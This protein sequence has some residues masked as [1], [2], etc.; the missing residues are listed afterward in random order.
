MSATHSTHDTSQT[1][2]RNAAPLPADAASHDLNDGYVRTHE[3]L[4]RIQQELATS[5]R[6]L[7]AL[8]DE[9]TGLE[10]QLHLKFDELE[11]NSSDLSSLLASMHIAVVFLDPRFCLRRFTPAVADLFDLTATDAGRPL[12]E[13]SRKFNDPALDGD[14]ARVLAQL[15]PLAAEITSDSGRT[16]VRQALPYRT[17]ANRVEGVV[18]TFVDITER[19]RIEQ[20]FAVAERRQRIVLDA[21][22][23]YAIF[24]LDINGRVETWS[25]AAE[26]LLGYE[27]A[28]IVGST[29]DIV[30]TPGDREAELPKRLLAKAA[31]K[32]SVVADHFYMRRDGVRFWGSGMLYAVRDPAGAAVGFVKILRDNSQQRQLE[33]AANEA[34]RLAE[35]ANESKDHFLS[36]V[37]HEL[38]T[39]LSAMM[40]WSH[41]LLNQKDP[42]A[43]QLRE[44]LQAIRACAEEQRALIEDLVDTS[45]IAAGKLRLDR[46]PTDLVATMRS[47]VDAMRP[48]AAERGLSLVETHDPAIG[49][50]FADAHRVHQ[51]VSNLLANAV[52]FTP[53]GGHVS[54][55]ST[56]D[57]DDVVIRVSDTGQGIRHDLLSGIFERFRQAEST[58]TKEHRGLGLGLSISRQLVELHGGKI[59]AASPGVGLGST[60]T[61]TLPF[62]VLRPDQLDGTSGA[63]LLETPIKLCGLRLLLVEDSKETLKALR[64]LLADAGAIVETATTARDAFTQFQTNPPELLLSDLGLPREDGNELLGWI[65]VWEKQQDRAEVPAYAL[66]AYADEANRVRALKSGFL[67]CLTKPVNQGKLLSTLAKHTKPAA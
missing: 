31:K 62:P 2:A 9:I 38:R 59:S 21:L 29:L 39:P 23:E 65:R 24:T 17:N 48:V 37:S 7:Q 49:T 8:N 56:R 14:V 30:Y 3:E 57:G 27:T 16:Y 60:F 28:E 10:S 45:R 47:T 12:S 19:K 66:T 34:R 46:S 11:T 36:N 13:L 35:Q 22:R 43:A 4:Q 61:V 18:V 32:D 53:T 1:L 20:R 42:T 44:G 58:T 55:R 50:V 41:M 5:K 6:A 63:F 26:R 52:K 33:D 64:A 67:Q 15:A 51:V 40:L 54:L 25:A